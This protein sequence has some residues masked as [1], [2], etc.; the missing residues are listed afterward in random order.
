MNRPKLFVA[1]FLVG[2]LVTGCTSWLENYGTTRN[3]TADRKDVTINQLIE[4]WKSYDIY[5]N[6]LDVKLPLGILFSPKNSDTK[7]TGDYWHKVEDQKTVIEIVRWIYPNTL[8]QP[9]LIELQGSDDRFL[10]YLYYSWGPAIL[11]KIDNSTYYIFQLENPEDR[12]PDY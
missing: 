6:G 7:L 3:L 4:N 2:L 1:L 11:K 10:G 5:Y 9:Y 12:R 8:V